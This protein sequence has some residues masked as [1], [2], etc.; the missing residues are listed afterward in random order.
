MCCQ[1]MR[2]W[3]EGIEVCEEAKSETKVANVAFQL[4]L[5]ISHEPWRICTSPS[6]CYSNRIQSKVTDKRQL[7]CVFSILYVIWLTWGYNQP[8]SCSFFIA[9]SFSSIAWVW[10]H[11]LQSHLPGEQEQKVLTLALQLQAP[12]H[13]RW[14]YLSVL[15][16]F[17]LISPSSLYPSNFIA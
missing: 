5:F 14:G 3:K 8:L 6:Y 13:R 12:L 17:H 10:W 7:A 15:L 1:V 4:C 16:F 11:L 9:S 2:D